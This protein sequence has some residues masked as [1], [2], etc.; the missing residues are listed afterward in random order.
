[1]NYSQFFNDNIN[2]SLF[3]LKGSKT[4]NSH[5]D[6]PVLTMLKRTRDRNKRGRPHIGHVYLM[7]NRLYFSSFVLHFP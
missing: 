2:N 1:M 4:T 3:P 7:L 5:S 6:K